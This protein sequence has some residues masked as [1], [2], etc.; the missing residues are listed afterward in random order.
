MNEQII[1]KVKIINFLKGNKKTDDLNQNAEYELY[2]TPDTAKVKLFTK[3]I[4]INRCITDMEQKI[5]NWN[6]VSMTLLSYERNRKKF[7]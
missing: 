2:L 6:I 7:Q 3:M 5:G 4:E 1:H